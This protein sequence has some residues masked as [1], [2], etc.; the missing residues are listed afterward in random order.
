M[1]LLSI[2][3]YVYFTIVCFI[4]FEFCIGHIGFRLTSRYGE[5]YIPNWIYCILIILFSLAWPIT[6]IYII[7]DMEE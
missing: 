2:F 1:N 6:C 3:I 4:F 7:R 5:E